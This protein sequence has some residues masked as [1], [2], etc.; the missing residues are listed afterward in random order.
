MMISSC[1]STLWVRIDLQHPLL[2]KET[3]LLDENIKKNETKFLGTECEA[4]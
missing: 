1:F 3:V 2:V 4:L